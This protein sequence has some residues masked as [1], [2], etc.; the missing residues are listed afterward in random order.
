MPFDFND[1]EM[2][3]ESELV[4]CFNIN[5]SMQIWNYCVL[6]QSS[7]SRGLVPEPPEKS[8]TGTGTGTRLCHR[9]RDQALSLVPITKMCLKNLQ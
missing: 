7:S 1:P 4:L 8:G 2:C 3:L 5:T 9:Y 6:T